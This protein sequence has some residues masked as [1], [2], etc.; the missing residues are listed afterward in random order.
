MRICQCEVVGPLFP[1]GIRILQVSTGPVEAAE[2][3]LRHQVACLYHCNRQVGPREGASVVLMPLAGPCS[4]L[5]EQSDCLLPDTPVA[6]VCAHVYV[7]MSTTVHACHAE[8]IHTYSCTC[9]D[10]CVR[11]WLSFLRHVSANVFIL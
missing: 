1:P 6:F 3:G 11:A 4:L 8:Y 5:D 10:A 7:A 9:M 2:N